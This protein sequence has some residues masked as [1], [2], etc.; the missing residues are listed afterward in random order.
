ME[1][2]YWPTETLIL[3]VTNLKF[4]PIFYEAKVRNGNSRTRNFKKLNLLGTEWISSSIG[5]P[6]GTRPVFTIF[7]QSGW[8][9]FI[10]RVG[11]VLGSHVHSAVILQTRWLDENSVTNLSFKIYQTYFHFLYFFQNL[12]E[13]IN[14]SILW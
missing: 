1:G 6:P 13:S 5:W 2:S 9:S 10:Q 4:D 11:E 3:E 14:T 12:W 8:E 7:H